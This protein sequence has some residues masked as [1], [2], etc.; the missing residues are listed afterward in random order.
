MNVNTKVE[1]RVLPNRR[2]KLFEDIVG[3]EEEEEEVEEEEEEEEDE[4]D[5]GEM[6]LVKSKRPGRVNPANGSDSEEVVE[7]CGIREETEVEKEEIKEDEVEEDVPVLESEKSH[8]NDREDMVVEPPTVLES[9]MSHENERDTMDG[10]VV[11]LVKE[12]DRELSN[13]IQ[14]EGGCI[15]HEKV[16][17]NETIETVELSEEQ[18]QHLECQN[19]EANEEDVVEVDNVA[20]E[21]EDGG[22]HDA[23]DD[24]LVK[25]DEKPS[26]HK[27]DIAVEQSN[28]AAAEAI[29]KPRIKQ[30]RRCGLCG[31]GT[32]GKPP[33]KLVQDVGDSEN[34][35][36]SSSASEEPNYDVWD[37]FGDEPGWLGRLLGPINDRYGIAG[38]WVHQHCAVWSPEVQFYSFPFYIP[39][40]Q[41]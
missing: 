7:I 5:G 35:A 32:D 41:T 40:F 12:D 1:E 13:C 33:K 4:S 2:R 28:K 8:G 39:L 3:N 14:S 31:G 10:Y 16:E 18:V 36:Y 6:M 19:E 30:G 37:G 34:E 21:V 38:I 27:N 17:I 15:G 29:G 20:E 26:E 9:E 25:V 23:K 11:E 22:D 24:G